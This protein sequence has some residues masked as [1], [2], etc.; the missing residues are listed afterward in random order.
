[1]I[2]KNSD[3]KSRLSI[4][5]AVII[6]ALI[7]FFSSFEGEES[8]EQSL[9]ISYFLAGAEEGLFN[10]ELTDE[11]FMLLASSIDGPV[12]KAA[13]MTEYGILAAAVWLALIF[14]MEEGKKLYLYNILICVAYAVSDEIHQSF[15]AERW[16][17]PRDVLVDSVGVVIANWIIYKKR[18]H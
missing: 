3:L 18:K 11:E 5:P 9:L 8:G 15:V 16:G 12:R 1:M 14:R 17:S 7:F 4:L 10:M 2:K 6:M 13:H